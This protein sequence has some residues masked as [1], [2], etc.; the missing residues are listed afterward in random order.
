MPC[1]N[2]TLLENSTRYNFV[3]LCCIKAMWL[4]QVTL[5][6]IFFF[7]PFILPAALLPVITLLDLPLRSL[8]TTCLYVCF[9]VRSLSTTRV[10]IGFSETF[11]SKSLH[12]NFSSPCTAYCRTVPTPRGCE[13]NFYTT[14]ER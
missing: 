3:P 1:V 12:F 5:K 11:Y 4:S 7:V 6:Y 13:N 14:K 10:I 2:Q 9:R 8:L